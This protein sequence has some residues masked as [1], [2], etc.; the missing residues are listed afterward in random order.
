MRSILR[1]AGASL[2][3]VAACT[4]T[5][6]DGHARELGNIHFQ[7][8]VPQ[9]TA[10]TAVRP[11]QSFTMTV[12]TWG[13]GCTTMG[14]TEVTVDRDTV[15]VRPYDLVEKGANIS[16]P[17]ILK[18]FSHQVTLRLDQPGMNTVRI[19]GRRPPETEPLLITWP[20]NVTPTAP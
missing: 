6:S 14:D 9:I 18:T 3:A 12:V 16:C 13:G 10:P 15:D 17:D 1:L 19:H 5:S 8:G 11:G 2:L 4:P 20:I 7:D